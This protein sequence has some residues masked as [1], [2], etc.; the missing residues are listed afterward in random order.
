MSKT[1]RSSSST[2]MSSSKKTPKKTKGSKK[3]PPPSHKF[4]ISTVQQKGGVGKTTLTVHLAH[5]IHALRP[6][7][8]I[9][10]A[11]ADP[12]KSASNWIKRGREL[13]NSSLEGYVVAQ[14][15]LGKQMNRELSDIEADVLF[16]D[17]PPA[18]ESIS[19]RSALYA[20]LML[21]PVGASILDVEAARQTIEV[22]EE[23]Q[24]VDP[25]KHILLVPS[26]LRKNTA[27]SRE[28]RPLLEE[29]GIVSQS[30]ISLRVAY[31]D[32]AIQGEGIHSY[33]PR[34][35]SYREMYQLANEVLSFIE[36]SV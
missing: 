31:A 22:C 24:S 18:I 27:T 19:L 21:I 28:L 23:A 35:A 30:S 29:W 12:Q 11:D 10:V 1:P 36:E 5:M 15:G 13:G 17:S 32:A 7:W 26:K 14:D 8:K 34:S 4:I 9:A 6:H 16:I 33:A 25:R 3:Q 20:D 2:K